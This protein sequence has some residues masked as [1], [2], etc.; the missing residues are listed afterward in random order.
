MAHKLIVE[1]CRNGKRITLDDSSVY[2]VTAGDIPKAIC[3]YGSQRVTVT[4]N[5]AG[6]VL[7]KNLDTLNKQSIRVTCVTGSVPDEVDD[8]ESDD[9]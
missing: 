9:E 7:L 3:W 8:E 4:R 6:G 5:P 2:D 1:V